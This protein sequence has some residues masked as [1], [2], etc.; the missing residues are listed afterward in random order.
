MPVCT[1]N[2][3][4]AKLGYIFPSTAIA[5]GYVLV[6]KS[7]CGA[8]ALTPIP[9]ASASSSGMFVTRLGHVNKKSCGPECRYLVVLE[10]VVV[11]L[12]LSL[13]EVL[14]KV[15][16]VKVLVAVLEEVDIVLVELVL[17]LELVLLLK[18]EDVEVLVVGST[19]PRCPRPI[20]GSSFLRLFCDF[21]D[22]LLHD[23]GFAD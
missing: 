5:N 8:E 17:V 14:V 23:F 10:D 20:L 15:E 1:L 11:E 3:S 4:I 16:D 2:I 7:G 9:N 22:N 13:V 19:F 21:F 18:V 6:T 12:V